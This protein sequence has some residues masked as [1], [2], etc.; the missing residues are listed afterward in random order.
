MFFLQ[1]GSEQVMSNGSRLR[2]TSKTLDVH[3]WLKQTTH[4]CKGHYTAYGHTFF[5]LKETVYDPTK[6]I[7]TIPCNEWLLFSKPST[8]WFNGDY[9]PQKYSK[10]LTFVTSKGHDLHNILID[11]NI[12]IVIN[13]EYP[14]NFFHAMTQWY[15]IY[16]LSKLLRFEMKKVNVLLL[17]HGPV[18]HIDKQWQHLFQDVRKAENLTSSIYLR[19]AIFNIPGHESPM[20]YFDLIQLPFAEEFSKYFLNNFGLKSKETYDCKKLVIT[21]ILRHDYFMHPGVSDTKRIT[22]R[23]FKNEGELIATL[24]SEFPGHVV[25]TLIAED[26]S[27]PEQLSMTSN[28]D[29]LIGMHGCVLTQTFF[30]PKHAVVLEMFPSFWEI[31]MFFKSIARWRNIKHEHWRNENKKYEYENHYMYVPINVIQNFSEHARSH[32]DCSHQL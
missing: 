29:I 6:D 28:T 15:N 30:L 22:E 17:D 26:M 23:K 16:V 3:G 21:L 8:Y 7:F 31:K 9:A 5:K 14:H 1:I 12:T 20:Y 25:Q 27:L 24:R 18:V 10:S 19:D 32:F 4:F 11:N 13:R 2:F